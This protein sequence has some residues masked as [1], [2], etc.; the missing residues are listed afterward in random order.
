MVYVKGILCGLTAIF[1]A[2]CFP[3]PW[4]AFRGI[5][6]GKATGLAAVAGGLAESVFSPLFWILAVIFFALFF[7]ASRL[8]NRFLRV[9]LFWIPTLTASVVCIASGAVLT[10]LLIRFRHP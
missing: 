9:I 3:G 1:L 4:F 7:A 8:G 2:E 5:S 6:Q 10:Y